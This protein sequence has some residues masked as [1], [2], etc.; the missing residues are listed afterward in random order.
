MT[1]DFADTEAG[2][3]VAVQSDGKIVVVGK[4]GDDFVVARY[5][6]NGTLDSSFDSDGKNT[7]GFL[8]GTDIAYGVAIQSD[9]KILSAGESNGNF[10]LA[11]YRTD[12]DH[13]N[14]F[15]VNGRVVTDF[16]GSDGGYSVVVQ[17]VAN[18]KILVAGQS[19]G[20]FAIARYNSNGSLDNTFDGD[21]RLTTD[22]D[23]NDVGRSIILQPDGKIVVAGNSDGSFAIA[24]YNTNGSLDNTFGSGGKVVTGLGGNDIG[25]S[26]ILQPDGKILV[27][28]NSGGNFALV[29]Y[30]SNG[31]LDTTFD[32]NGIVITGLGSNDIGR[33][34]ALQSDG[35]ILVA[36]NSGGSFAIVRYRINN[37]PTDLSLSPT[38]FNENIAASTDVATFS[39]T[40]SDTVDTSFTY[41]LVSGAGDTNNGAFTINGNQLQ[42][43]SSPDYETQ[44]SYSIRVRTTDAAGEY[45]EEAL[46]ISITNINEPPTDFASNPSPVNVDENIPVST[47][48]ITFSSTDPEGQTLTYT[49]V[50]GTGSDDNGAFTINGGNKLRFNSSPD[51]ETKTSYKIRVSVSDGFNTPEEKEFVI[52][53]NDINEP[54]TGFISTPVT[55]IAVNENIET[56][57][58]VTTFSVTDPEGQTLT[59]SFVAGMGDDDNDAFTINGN[60]L[61][62][63]FSPDYETKTSYKIRVSVSDGF[64]TPEEQE[65]V[66]DINDINEPPTD[67]ALSPISVDENVAASTDIAT[68]SSTDEE[69]NTL[70]YSF[71]TGTGSDDNGAFTIDGDK[72]QFNSSPDY[73]TK[74][75][76]K[77]RVS[78]SDGSN[79]PEE[80]EFVININDI[81][82]SFT[83]L[84]LSN[85]EVD[86]NAPKNKEIGA[87]STDNPDENDPLTYDLVAGT[88]DT[89]NPVFIIKGNKLFIRKSPNFETKPSYNIRVK[90]TD[91]AMNSKEEEFMINVTDIDVPTKLTKVNDKDVFIVNSD[92]EKAKLSIKLT[93]QSSNLL[94]ELGVFIVDD[95]EGT[96]D[97]IGP[98]EEGYTEAALERSQVLFSTIVKIPNG[99]I[100]KATR[101]LEV[102]SSER[103]RFFIVR[104]STL[105]EVMSGEGSLDD[106]LFSSDASFNIKNL[107][108]GGFSLGWRDA[109]GANTDDFQDLVVTANVTD[110]DLVLGTGLQGKPQ[111]EVLDL[112][113]VTQVV[114]AEFVVNREAVH[115]NFIGFYQVIDEDGG[116]DTDGDGTADLLVGQAGYTEAAIRN[117]VGGLALTVENQSAASYTGTLQ[118]GGIFVPFMIVDGTP[119][120]FLASNSNNNPAVYFP[121]LGANTDQT[122]HVRLLGDNTFG[123]ED[124]AHGG[125]YDFNDIIV[126]VNL[127]IA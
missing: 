14:S 73:E 120:T 37:A 50:A 114:N 66:I 117:R 58:V 102:D 55:P 23:G 111:G 71:V 8:G 88:G 118:P 4:S 28:G 29:R 18:G 78:V 42:F 109:Q 31:V 105:D 77:I 106:V 48:I 122:D 107:E 5:L 100:N 125:D 74:T 32:T 9:G 101:L 39:T 36:G 15:G 112:R 43:N 2:Y 3:G 38:S 94:N 91:T 98:G 121:F 119:D 6:V 90:A 115:N 104:N 93:G 40:D 16:G 52:N 124:L 41:T 116:I 62:F 75:S 67:F 59:Y 12:G 60:E 72:L 44:T 24:R 110:D 19:N 46:T 80:K 92:N 76:Y 45:Y 54:P 82:E 26:V 68:F 25:R 103:L 126:K 34:I 64:N 127:S 69:G 65:F 20:N 84:M 86:D 1:T 49:L 30:T 61:Q 79:T 51:Y 13:D 57:T 33:S 17:Q 63:N 7:H 22:F 83:T 53:I 87:F 99:F 96:I 11:R 21:G 27:A 35:K 56:S 108:D 10:A 95:E 81:N 70:T 97:G 113:D 89:D 47:D 123:F 85:T